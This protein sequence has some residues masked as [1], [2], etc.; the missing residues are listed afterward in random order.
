MRRNLKLM[1]LLMALMLVFPLAAGIFDSAGNAINDE[2]GE[3][4]IKE[5]VVK[6]LGF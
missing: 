3:N 1:A 4:G 2:T 5:D 6:A